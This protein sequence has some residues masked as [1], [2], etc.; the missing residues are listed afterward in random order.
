MNEKDGRGWR[1]EVGEEGTGGEGTGEEGTGG[2][3]LSSIVVASP[4][5]RWIPEVD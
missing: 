4:S 5:N 3:R 1:G 2:G